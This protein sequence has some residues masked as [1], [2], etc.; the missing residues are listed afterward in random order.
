MTTF[1]RA[2]GIWR[3]ASGIDFVFTTGQANLAKYPKGD[4]PNNN[5]DAQMNAGDWHIQNYGNPSVPSAGVP[6]GVKYE[7]Y[8]LGHIFSIGDSGGMGSM[9]AI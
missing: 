1:L 9:W 3:R 4:I 5:L 6:T 7:D 8:D 2:G